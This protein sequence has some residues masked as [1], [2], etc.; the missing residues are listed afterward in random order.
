MADEDLAARETDQPK[1]QINTQKIYLKDVSFETPNSPQI[2]ALDW[3]P[4]MTIDFGSTVQT[5]GDDFYEVIMSLTVTTKTEDKTAYLA[6]V[7]QA[8]VFM[9]QGFEEEE[10]QRALNVACLHNIYPYACAAVSD[11]VSKGGFPQLALSPISFESVYR[12]RLQQ[13]KE[14][15]QPATEED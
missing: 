12:Q 14:E 6:E 3:K 2:F 8:G 7:H 9:I 15:Q 4:E 10:L 11:I 5:V 1:R 13:A